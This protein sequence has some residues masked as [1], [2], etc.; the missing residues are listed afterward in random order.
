MHL[1]ASEAVLLH[2][3]T[4][5][6]P[7]PACCFSFW[8]RALNQYSGIVHVCATEAMLLLAPWLTISCCACLP[9]WLQNTLVSYNT[10]FNVTKELAN[11][12]G[13]R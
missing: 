2:G 12:P 3:S 6:A 4:L 9:A 5:T 10:V 13:P 7:A 8:Y 11:M 1:R